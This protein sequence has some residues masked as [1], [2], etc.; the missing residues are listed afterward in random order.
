M[1]AFQEAYG[2][3]VDGTV[4]LGDVLFLSGPITVTSSVPLGDAVGQGSEML[5]VAASGRSVSFDV[6]PA[7]VTM[8]AAGTTVDVEVG[9]SDVSGTVVEVGRDATAASEDVD[10]T[11]EVTVELTD[12]AGVA[13][14]PDGAE[15]TITLPQES[16]AGVLAVPAGALHAGL[17]GGFAVT[18]VNADGTHPEVPV[19][20]GFASDG[21]V[22]I[23]E[24]PQEGDRVA[25]A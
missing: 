6:D 15:A 24:G 11:V 19:T 5:T 9:G 25:V 14:V 16:H 8:L 22:E 10:P 7:E 1:E 3:E 20:P 13:A 4:E 12:P 23:V 21:V 18:V 2:F 17:E